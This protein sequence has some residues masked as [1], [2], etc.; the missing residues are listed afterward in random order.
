VWVYLLKR[1]DDVFTIFKQFI[2]MVEKNSGRSIKCLITDNGCE[3]TS[4]EFNKYCKEEGIEEH[5]TNAYTSQQNNVVERMNM[6][7]LERAR[8]VLSNSKLQQ[9]LWA[10]EVS[11][12]CYILD[13]S[14]S[15]ASEC[16]DSKRCID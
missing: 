12:S 1:K 10:E 13:L 6:T 3:Y 2:A 16:L 8:S 5:K 4:M 9:Q 7:L 15:N 14:P 11:R